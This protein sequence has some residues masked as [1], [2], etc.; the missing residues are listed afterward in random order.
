LS[1]A[2]AANDSTIAPM[3]RIE[4]SLRIEDTTGG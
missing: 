4:A 2:N 1:L 3:H